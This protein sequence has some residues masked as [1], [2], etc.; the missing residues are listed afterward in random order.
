[1]PSGNRQAPTQ[2]QQTNSEPWSVAQPYLAQTLQ[3]ADEIYRDPAAGPSYFPFSTVANQSQQ[4]LDS[5]SQ[6][7]NMA[8]QGSPLA[9]AAQSNALGLFNSGGLSQGQQGALNNLNPLASGQQGITT[10]GLYQP[11]ASGQYLE[12][13]NPY[14]RSRLEDESRR[15]AD[16][17]NAQFSMAG[18]YGSGAHTGVL[19]DRI[20]QQRNNAMEADYNRE[21]GYQMQAIQGLT[22]IE[23][24]N[25]ANRMAATN[26]QLGTYANAN[27]DV[28]RLMGLSPTLEQMR[29][30]PAQMLAGVGAA[31]DARNTALLQDDI[32]RYQAN[33]M[34]PWER[35]GLAANLFNG[36][37]GRGATSTATTT[38]A[39]NT[40]SP[41][42]TGIGGA[43]SGAA[44]GS[45]FGPIGAGIGAVGG[46]LAGLFR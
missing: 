44:A 22:G 41:F 21:R 19:A 6:I 23:N 34:A 7:E 30:Q 29:Y 43:V 4:T 16:Q 31:Q 39:T 8:R 18:R 12:N 24:Q 40:T 36:A 17:V 20:G 10:A 5:L 25:I 26:A 37:G 13:G 2:T 33:A 35:L 42:V 15:T 28:Q 32:N 14:F 45:I 11:M 38:G 1:M 9:S 46:G 27:Q 3:R